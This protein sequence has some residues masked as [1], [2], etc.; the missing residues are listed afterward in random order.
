MMQR[1]IVIVPNK[2]TTSTVSVQTSGDSRKFF[3]AIY[4]ENLGTAGMGQIKKDTYFC[5]VPPSDEKF[6]QNLIDTGWISVEQM[7][8]CEKPVI[9]NSDCKLYFNIYSYSFEDIEKDG[10]TMSETKGTDTYYLDISG[11]TRFNSNFLVLFSPQ[12]KFKIDAIWLTD[13]PK[14]SEEPEVPDPVEYDLY[15]SNVT[16]STT[17]LNHGDST[18][19]AVTLRNLADEDISDVD[20][21]VTFYCDGSVFETVTKTISIEAGRFTLLQSDAEKNLF[22][23]AHSVMATVYFADE[24][25]AYDDTTNNNILKS[26]FKVTD[27]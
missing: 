5:F 21:T 25:V 4:A 17:T 18:K 1:Y 14:D 22:F 2:G 6:G 23:G 20:V 15:M 26:R 12:S 13:T 3:G 19:F 9:D 8:G 16:P 27:N 11:V 10:K 24:N 7:E